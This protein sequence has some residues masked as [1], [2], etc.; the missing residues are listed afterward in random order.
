MRLCMFYEIYVKAL[1]MF[2]RLSVNDYDDVVV[3]IK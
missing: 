3:F 1:R 2:W